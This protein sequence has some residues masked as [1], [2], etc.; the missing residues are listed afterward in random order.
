MSLKVNVESKVGG[1]GV[2]NAFILSEVYAL[3]D[4]AMT[5]YLSLQWMR[6]TPA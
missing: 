1:G 5:D 2:T 4:S 3:E 6:V